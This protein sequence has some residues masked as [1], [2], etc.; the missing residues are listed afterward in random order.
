MGRP[1]II[2]FVEEQSRIGILSISLATAAIYAMVRQKFHWCIRRRYA[3]I[4][5]DRFW[6]SK[7]DS[8]MVT[9]AGLSY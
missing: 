3:G 4:L 9:A 8:R 6:S 7:D 5:P 1:F 2:L